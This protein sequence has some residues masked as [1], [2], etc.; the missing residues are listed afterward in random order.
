MFPVRTYAHPAAA[1]H[2]VT[3]PPDVQQ[4]RGSLYSHTVAGEDVSRS[5]QSKG[6]GAKSATQNSQ[7]ERTSIR[8][9]CHGVFNGRRSHNSLRPQYSRDASTTVRP[10]SKLVDLEPWM[11][12]ARSGA[13]EGICLTGG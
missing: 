5:C 12:F 2:T 8:S 10:E 4:Q 7:S 3:P 6:L 11:G 13:M 1:G 9:R